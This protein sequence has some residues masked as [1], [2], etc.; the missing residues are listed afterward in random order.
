MFGRHNV[1]RGGIILMLGKERRDNLDI[2]SGALTEPEEVT[3]KMAEGSNDIIFVFSWHGHMRDSVYRVTTVVGWS[4]GCG[5]GDIKTGG[6]Y[7]L[8]DEGLLRD[9]YRGSWRRL[10]P[11]KIQAKV[12]RYSA[13]EI[14]SCLATKAVFKLFF[15]LWWWWGIHKIVNIHAEV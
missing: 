6:F 3:N 15:H 14:H 8:I 9:V 2:R 11:L 5:G 7:G 1:T 4:L 10:A 13:H 12:I